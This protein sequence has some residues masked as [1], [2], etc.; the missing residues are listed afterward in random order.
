MLKEKEWGGSSSNQT[1][2]KGEPNQKKSQSQQ[3]DKKGN[4]EAKKKFQ[5]AIL[6]L[7]SAFPS[8]L[9]CSMMTA[10]QLEM[11]ERTMNPHEQVVVALRKITK[12][13]KETQK[14][15]CG[16]KET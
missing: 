7:F 5:K 2:K 14:E 3:W 16:T 6:L 13:K 15:K 9:C 4:E 11:V 8:P 12:I 1:K 10:Y